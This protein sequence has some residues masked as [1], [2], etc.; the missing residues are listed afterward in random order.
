MSFFVYAV[1]FSS[2]FIIENMKMAETTQSTISTPHIIT[3]ESPVFQIEL[4]TEVR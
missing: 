4:M 2:R 3:S 1:A